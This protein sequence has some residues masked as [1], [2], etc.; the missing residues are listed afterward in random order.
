MFLRPL[1]GLE[2]QRDSACFLGE[3]GK[4]V[5][6]REGSRVEGVLRSTRDGEV[7]MEVGGG[8]RAVVGSSSMDRSLAEAVLAA[9]LWNGE[10]VQRTGN[11]QTFKLLTFDRTNE[12]GDFLCV[13][14]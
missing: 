5:E 8:G 6:N 9:L 10:R 2:G 14:S 3:E 7:G 12:K 13:V 4:D 11:F 1:C